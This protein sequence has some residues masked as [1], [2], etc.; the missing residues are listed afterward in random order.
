MDPGDL[1]QLGLRRPRQSERLTE[2]DPPD[3]RETLRLRLIGR[4]QLDMAELVRKQMQRISE[5]KRMTCSAWMEQHGTHAGLDHRDPA[6]HVR[7]AVPVSRKSH[8]HNRR[9]DT[10]RRCG[11]I[12]CRLSCLSATNHDDGKTESY[13]RPDNTGHNRATV[14]G[15]S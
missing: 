11:P 7:L 12:K 5:R 6:R 14:A 15:G 3:H 1:G 8:A 2:P 10:D 4:L 9:L 13:Q